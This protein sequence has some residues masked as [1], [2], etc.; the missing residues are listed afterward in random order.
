[1]QGNWS[2]VKDPPFSPNRP[3]TDPPT[4]QFLLEEY[5]MR[6]LEY[7]ENLKFVRIEC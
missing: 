4:H 3:P 1:M 6:I 5:A 7:A 2:R